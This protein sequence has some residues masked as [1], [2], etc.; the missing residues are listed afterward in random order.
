MKIMELDHV[1]HYIPD[2][3]GARKQYNALGFEM[4]DGGKHSYGTQNIVTR[5]H[6]AYIEPIC[7]ENWDLLRAK[8][9][10]WVCDLL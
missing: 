4:R 2:L 8:R 6:R 7:I 3:E 1:V 9:P 5:L 10:Q